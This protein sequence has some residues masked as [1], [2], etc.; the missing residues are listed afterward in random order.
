VREARQQVHRVRLVEGLSLA[1]LA[2]ARVGQAMSPCL[3]VWLGPC[4][5][6]GTSF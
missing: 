1:W 6:P 4:L 2:Q 5:F 3:V